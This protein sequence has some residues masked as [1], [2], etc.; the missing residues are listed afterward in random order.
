MQLTLPFRARPAHPW[1]V[2]VAGAAAV[3]GACALVVKRQTRNAERDFPPKGRFVTVDGVRLHFTVHGRDDAPQTVLLL[4]G[5]G[6]MAEEFD[7]SGLVRQVAERYRVVVFDRPGY[8]YSE[9]PR[10]RRWGPEEQADLLHAAIQR[11]GIVEPVV[12][13]H[14]WGALVALAMGLRHAGD[15]GGLVLASGYY[16][17]SVRLDVPLNAGPAIPAVGTLMRHTVSPLL[18]RLLWPLQ[19]R[20]MFAP[21]RPTSAFRAR[22]PVAMSMRPGQLRA[23]AEESAMMVPAAVALRRRYR[24]LDVP[25]VLVAG[26]RDRYVSTA[27]HSSR[28]HEHVDRSWLRVVEDTGHMVHHVATGQVMAAIDQAAGLAWDRE[29]LSRP[30]AGLKA[31]EAPRVAVPPPVV[32]CATSG[33]P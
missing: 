33:A 17:P 8:G 29:L 3:L 27:W 5:N 13:G 26:A 16:F 7:I 24:D 30:P 2:A 11:L 31:G 32:P 20:R 9:R 15:L 12:L 25:V 19:V 1:L 22:Y 21:A 18:A 6:T 28:L 4:H 10:G 23:S 14:S